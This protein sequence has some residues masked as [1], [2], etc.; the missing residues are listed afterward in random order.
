MD[1]SNIC[2]EIRRKM[3]TATTQ[4]RIVTRKPP[5]Y[6][7]IPR[8]LNFEILLGDLIYSCPKVTKEVLKP[9]VECK[10]M[11]NFYQKYKSAV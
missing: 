11:S 8:I 1:M 6:Q 3:Y 10:I 4:C 2:S 5:A 9:K 7:M